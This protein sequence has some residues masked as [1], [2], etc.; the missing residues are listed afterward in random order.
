M[1]S[2]NNLIERKIL[3]AEKNI[4]IFTLFVFAAGYVGT[5]WW[6]NS[7]RQNLS[8]PTAILWVLIGVQFF[9]LISLFVMSSLR[10]KQ[11]GYR[12]PGFALIS[13]LILSRIND[14]EL[15]VL[16]AFLLIMLILSER[17]HNVSAER[18]S[19]LRDT[20]PGHPSS[21]PF[22]LSQQ[23][24]ISVQ[25]GLDRYIAQFMGLEPS[26]RSGTSPRSIE[27]ITRD[28]TIQRAEVSLLED[29]ESFYGKDS[30]SPEFNN[31]LSTKRLALTM[32]EDLLEMKL[33]SQRAI[34]E[35]QVRVAS[36]KLLPD[37]DHQCA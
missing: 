18:H 34:R 29:C 4:F 26:T 36:S 32:A 14:W 12:H 21:F 37:V 28:V 22:W 3:R 9:C 31:L 15:V 25:D 24:N 30:M 8:T 1:T 11:C 20:Q 27:E 23:E 13:V 17:N 10:A 33:E 7:L 5:T 16:P 35:A 2:V 19:W 6:L